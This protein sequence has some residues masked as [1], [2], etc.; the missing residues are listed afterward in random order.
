VPFKNGLNEGVGKSYYENGQL[1]VERGWR[2][3]KVEGL[4]KCFDEYGNEIT[5]T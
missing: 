2:N 5:C 3:G 1:A 4:W